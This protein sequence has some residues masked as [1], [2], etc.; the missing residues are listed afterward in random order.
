[1]PEPGCVRL[2][3]LGCPP[4]YGT[5]RPEWWTA[6]PWVTNQQHVRRNQRPVSPGKRRAQAAQQR[7]WTQRPPWAEPSPRRDLAP[8]PRSRTRPVPGARRCQ[9][10][11]W[12]R[13][14]PRAAGSRRR[15]STT[16]CP[17]NPDRP[18]SAGRAHPRAIRWDRN[19]RWSASAAPSRR[20]G[21]WL[22]RWVPRTLAAVPEARRTLLSS[23][24]WLADLS[25]P[26]RLPG[27]KTLVSGGEGPAPPEIQ[28][29]K[30]VP[31]RAAKVM[32]SW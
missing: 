5:G 8:V 15:S 17:P 32:P 30:V 18:G 7:E 3:A 27:A 28:A 4:G 21:R 11:R 1:L 13:A 19:P 31:F 26:L 9:K 20:R 23:D 16:L 14:P 12:I 6:Q 24:G 29:P 25:P 2:V 22:A 10:A